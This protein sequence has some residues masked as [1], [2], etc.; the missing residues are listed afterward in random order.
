MHSQQ[1]IL[2]VE[3]SRHGKRGVKTRLIGVVLIALGV[4]DSLL[5]LRGGLPSEEYLILIALGFALFAIGAVRGRRHSLRR[6]N[7]V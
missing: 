6:T 5:T 1:S 7:H 2:Y 4:L 3:D